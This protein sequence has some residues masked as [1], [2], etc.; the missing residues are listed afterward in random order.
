[1][2]REKYAL[3]MEIKEDHLL[4]HASGVRTLETV[5]A[6]THEVFEATVASGLSKTLV[7]VRELAGRLGALESY[8]LVTD[9]FDRLRG[10]GIQKAAIIDRP[11]WPL[12]DWFLETVARNRGYNFRIFDNPADAREWLQ[13]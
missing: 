11:T 13:N 7:D 5:R 2:A 12:R 3:V 9:V 10:K 1:M 4:A 6:M 8:Y